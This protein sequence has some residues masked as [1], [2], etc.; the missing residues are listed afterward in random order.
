MQFETERLG[1]RKVDH[2]LKLGGLYHRNVCG[3]LTLENPTRIN[4]GLTICVSY[5]GAVTHQPAGDN[6]LPQ[7]VNRWKRE[8]CSERDDLM[9]PVIKERIC[10]NQE[11]SGLHLGYGGK[12][13]TD[14]ILGGCIHDVD[15]LSD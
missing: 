2:K 4:A 1:S 3:P 14:L 8:A 11:C 12:G 5:T 7:L 10:A 9:P 13:R 6:E 15:R